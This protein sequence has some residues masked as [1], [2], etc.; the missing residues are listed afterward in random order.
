MT[1]IQN[2]DRRKESVENV[3]REKKIQEKYIQMDRGDKKDEN[4]R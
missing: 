3:K 2:N 1:K 4:K